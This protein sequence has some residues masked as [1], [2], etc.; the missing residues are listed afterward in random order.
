MTFYSDEPE[1]L[2]DFAAGIP[3]PADCS[4]FFGF[5][6]VFRMDWSNILHTKQIPVLATARDLFQ[7]P[8]NLRVD[9][10]SQVF[11][12]KTLI[13]HCIF[14]KN[15]LIGTRQYVS[16][17]KISRIVFKDRYFNIFTGWDCGILIFT[18][19]KKNK[20]KKM[21]KAVLNIKSPVCWSR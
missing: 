12:I 17:F 13:D 16:K 5:P 8:L 2:Q 15:K 18:A 1:I 7:Y 20:R 9:L 21:I 4:R 14:Q 11:G 3:A 6:I 19:G 10:D